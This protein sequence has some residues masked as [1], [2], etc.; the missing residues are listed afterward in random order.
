LAQFKIADNADIGDTG[1]LALADARRMHCNDL[2][3]EGPDV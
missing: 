3:Y 1:A 2:E